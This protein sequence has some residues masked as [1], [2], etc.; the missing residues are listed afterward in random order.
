MSRTTFFVS[1]TALCLPLAAQGAAVGDLVPDF[2][3]PK[4]LNGDG[5][6]NIAE[7]FGSPVMLE[8][9]GTH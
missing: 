8:Y 4:L 6:Q 9:W 2:A 3:F 5:R 7:F 1:L